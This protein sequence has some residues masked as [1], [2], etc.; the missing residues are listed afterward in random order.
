M[1]DLL[2]GGAQAYQQ[3]GLFIAA[4]FCCGLGALILGNAVYQH[5]LGL[6]V[7]GTIIGVVPTGGL[8]APV[9]RYVAPDGQTREAQSDVSSGGV[10]GKETG[11]VV[12][13]LISPHNPAR[14]EQAGFRTNEMVVN[15][16][17]LVLLLLGS[18][19]V[20]WAFTAYPITPM[21]W[22][23]A[24]AMLILFGWRFHRSVIPKGKRLSK[25]EWRK[26]HL[27]GE[28]ASVDLARV[29]PIERLVSAEDIA[30][31]AQQQARQ[32]RITGP[33]V[34][35]VA[36]V[37]VGVGIW[38]S[39][40]IAQLEATGLRANGEVIDLRSGSGRGSGYH[41]VVRFRT[42]QNTRVQFQDEIG[43][44]PP[45]FRVGDKVTVLYLADDPRGAA[46]VDR[47]R[48]W[49]WAIPGILMFVSV[50]ALWLAFV[51]LRMGWRAT[52]G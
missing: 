11:R 9:Y 44:S 3:V 50:L 33:I 28:S 51:L 12:R 19:L 24:A 48:F 1:F 38:Q 46:I 26:Q 18:Y 36:I 8:Y 10:A 32:A 31:T 6:R 7:T 49:N 34:A 45:R 39:R 22:I 40:T 29:V 43:S 5:L 47:G 16:V 35:V 21:T 25:D 41:A 13:L 37:L 17:G 15:A 23:M 20:Y 30:K 4:L 2:F 27:L 42:A 14:A 52:R